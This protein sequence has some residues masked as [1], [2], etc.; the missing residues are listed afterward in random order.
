MTKSNYKEK[1]RFSRV[2]CALEALIRFPGSQSVPSKVVNLSIKGLL[3]SCKK[4][5]PVAKSCLIRIYLGDP[6]SRVLIDLK[7]NIVAVEGDLVRIELTEMDME[8][9]D[10]LKQ[11]I[12]LKS[13]STEVVQ[14]EFKKKTGLKPLKQPFG[15]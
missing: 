3:L 6:L 8:S 5:K 14:T 13:T 9:F 10:H 12:L 7:G 1:R 15:D 4:F 11:L 2:S